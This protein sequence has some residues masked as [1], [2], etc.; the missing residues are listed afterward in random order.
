M[1]RQGRFFVYIVQCKDGTYYTGYTSNLQERLQLH[2]SGNG[3]KFLRGRSPVQVVYVKE[4]WYYKRALDAERQLKKLTRK[5]KEELI[6]A[7]EQ[8]CG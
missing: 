8:V 5:Q 4:Y 1:R 3:A 7:H 6:E 2:N